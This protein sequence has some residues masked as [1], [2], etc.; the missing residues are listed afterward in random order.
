MKKLHYF[1]CAV[2]LLGNLTGVH[3]SVLSSTKPLFRLDSSDSS[4]DFSEIQRNDVPFS[5]NQSLDLNFEVS[6]FSPK[7]NFSAQK[8]ENPDAKAIAEWNSLKEKLSDRYK[9]E[10]DIR[11]KIKNYSEDGKDLLVFFDKKFPNLNLQSAIDTF[12]AQNTNATAPQNG[13]RI[14]GKGDSYRSYQV[15][16]IKNIFYLLKSEPNPQRPKAEEFILREAEAGHRIRLSFYKQVLEKL[17]EQETPKQIAVDLEFYNHIACP[18]ILLANKQES[19]QTQQFTLKVCVA[20]RFLENGHT[21]SLNSKKISYKLNKN[22]S[23]NAHSSDFGLAIPDF[24]IFSDDEDTIS[25]TISGQDLEAL[26]K[27]LTMLHENNMVHNDLHA[28]NIVMPD[29]VLI[30]F[31]RVL[32][33]ANPKRDWD[34]FDELANPYSSSQDSESS[35]K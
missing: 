27:I 24:G 34:Q 19:A 21:L 9:A 5:L 29:C 31:N 11:R 26:R 23:N 25:E 6:G 1:T 3:A 33:N 35:P 18:F 12:A 4:D 17:S 8:R 32:F 16:T 10:I 30:D 22:S 7:R 14:Q 15:R 20:S 28:G 2:F 13:L